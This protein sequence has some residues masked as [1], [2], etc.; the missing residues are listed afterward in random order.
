[1]N[2]NYDFGTT[3]HNSIP[4]RQMSLT[5]VNQRQQW[6]AYSTQG[7]LLAE[8]NSTPNGITWTEYEYDGSDRLLSTIDAYGNATSKQYDGL[9]RM[10]VEQHFDGSETAYTYDL[11]GNLL[12]KITPAIRE[13]DV[14]DAQI[15]YFYDFDRLE[16][17]EYPFSPQNRVRYYCCLLYTSPSPRDGATSRM[18]SSA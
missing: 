5:D 2:I 3:I 16:R 1:M 11:A 15:N 18:P 6:L 17:I 12:H 9:G 7:Q 14:P 4:V 13:R 8:G 10:L